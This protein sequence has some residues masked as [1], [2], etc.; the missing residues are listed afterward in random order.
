MNDIVIFG[1]TDFGRLLAYY[2][3]T[4]DSRKVVAYTV[5]RECIKED[6][7]CGLPVVPFEEVENIYPPDRY[8]ILLAIG[9]SKMNEVRKNV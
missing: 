7:F 4:D 9:N 1:N 8:D 3:K 5:N 6:S 2:L